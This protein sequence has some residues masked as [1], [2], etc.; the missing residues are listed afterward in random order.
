MADPNTLIP[1]AQRLCDSGQYDAHGGITFCNH[2]VS[3]FAEAAFNYLGLRDKTANELVDFLRGQTD[4][5]RL[6]YGIPLVADLQAA[7][8]AAKESAEVGKF[9]LIG[10]RI[11]AGAM[12]GHIATVVPGDLEFSQK[13]RDAGLPSE[14]PI[15]AQAGEDIFA[16]KKLSWGFSPARFNSGMFVVAVRD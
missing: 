11:G 12:G 7:F 13:W 15:I 1:I 4:G 3:D 8:R 9:V 6:L 2:F 14:L 5:W 10:V 16:N